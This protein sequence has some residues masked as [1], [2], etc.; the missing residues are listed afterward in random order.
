GV[1]RISPLIPG[2]DVVGT[3]VDSSDERWQRGDEVVLT[4]AGLGE[5]RNGGYSTHARV[6]SASLVRVPAQLGM[7]R[8]AAIGTAGFS[9]AQAVLAPERAG[10]PDGDIGPPRAAPWAC[11]GPGRRSPSRARRCR[12]ATSE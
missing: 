7:R 10:L 2:I 1:A 3:V 9:A 4:G 11:P 8:A 6:P 12:A 5:T